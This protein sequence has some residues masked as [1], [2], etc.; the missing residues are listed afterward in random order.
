MQNWPH[1]SNPE[2]ALG[3]QYPQSTPH[4]HIVEKVERR[5]EGAIR[6]HFTSKDSR[7][8]YFEISKYDHLSP[9][10]EYQRHKENLETRPEQFVV[11]ELKEIRWMSQPA[12]EYSFRWSQGARIV[13][14][15]EADN[16]TYRV[17]YDPYSPLNVQILS[18]LQWRY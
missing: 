3:F 11:S 8:L 9:Q 5:E 10:V 14:L 2:F 6:I 4:G 17:I 18:T 13:I 15:I 16:T 12:Y 7:E 1:F